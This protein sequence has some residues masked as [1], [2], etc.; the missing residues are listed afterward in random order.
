MLVDP[1]TLE[2][3]PAAERVLERLAPVLPPGISA[4]HEFLASQVEHA[5]PVFSDL[6]VAVGELRAFRERLA[7]AAAAEGLAVY[8]AGMPFQTAAYPTLTDEPRYERVRD[9][10]RAIIADHQ[11]NGLHVHVG[12][13]DRETGVRVLN[14][15]RPWLPTLLALS[16]NSPFWRGVDTGFASWR[17]IMMQ[18]WVTH[19]CPPRFEDA[20]DYDRRL[21]QLVGIGGTIDVETVA[22][23]A[24]LSEHYPTVEFRV[25]DAQLTPEDSVLLAA[26]ARGLVERALVSEAAAVEPE[27]LTAALWH[28]ARD[29]LSDRLVLDG[30]L[31]PAAVAVDAL[32]DHVLLSD[33]DSTLVRDGVQAL[34][35][36]GIG[37]SRQRT[38][39]AANGMVG[40]AAL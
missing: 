28:A 30:E 20:A 15:V 5:S 3:R 6:G 19:G 9:R 25:F 16:G 40:L 4:A 8:S 7:T 14:H 27:L 1:V 29:G 39:Y 33:A 37:A 12:V 22:W 21:R 36:G 38:A 10:F 11:I 23:N 34:T 13:P 32:L 24:R 26:L 35:E 17:T 31:V 18:R 2:Q